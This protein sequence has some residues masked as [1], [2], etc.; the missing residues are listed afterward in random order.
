MPQTREHAAVLAALGVER[1]VVAVTKS[2]VA[3]P[4]LALGEAAELLPGTPAVAVSA[5]TGAGLDELRAALG[6]LAAQVASRAG[7]G[8][9][10]LHV[11]RSFTIRG[12]GTVVTGTLWA[13][14]IGRGDHLVLLPAGREVRV[15]GVQVHDEAAER[16]EAGQRVAV[17]LVGVEVG[18]VG[19]GDVLAAADAGLEPS[20]VLAAR[21]D[22][23]VEPGTRLH[24]HH[25]TRETP[26]RVAS[27]GRLRLERP[28]VAARGDRL[29]LRSIAPPDTL[30]GGVV[31][32]AR[33]RRRRDERRKPAPAPQVAPAAPP[34]PEALALEAL[35]RD[36]GAEPPIE[37]ELGERAAHLRALRDAGRAVRVGR[38]LHY[39]PDALAE[40]EATVRRVIEGEGSITLAR[41]RDELGTTRKFAQ[42]LLEHFDSS[43]IT[44][45]KP[46]DS[47]VLRRR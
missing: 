43:R 34:A 41:L 31:I 28:L 39:H 11:D 44:L 26:A 1:G 21:L 33:P 17:N 47:R 40:I 16:A 25:G 29:V 18:E 30:G 14:S 36:A 8:P 20:Y 6:A 3:E 23:A 27:D 2:D 37:A 5:R 15:R 19:R 12:A 10:R 32:E 24:V 4:E 35:L 9:A 7:D 13:G 42:A 46:D 38:N 22:V 45:R